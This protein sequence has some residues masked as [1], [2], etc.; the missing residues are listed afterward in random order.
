MKITDLE[1]RISFEY[2]TIIYT[3]SDDE[4]HEIGTMQEDITWHVNSDE[5]EDRLI[6]DLFI[7]SIQANEPISDFGSM[8]VRDIEDILMGHEIEYEG[9]NVSTHEYYLQEEICDLY[10]FADVEFVPDELSE[11][12][13][14]QT[15]REIIEEIYYKTDDYEMQ[16]EEHEHALLEGL[17]T[18]VKSIARFS[19]EGKEYPI[20]LGQIDFSKIENPEIIEE[21]I[22]T[23]H[24]QFCTNEIIAELP[25]DTIY[26]SVE[27]FEPNALAWYMES[28]NLSS[29]PVMVKAIISHYPRL[30]EFTRHGEAG[31][32]EFAV[33][34]VTK[35]G[36]MLENVKNALNNDIDVV[37]AAIQQTVHAI[38]F[39]SDELLDNDEIARIAFEQEEGWIAL[40]Y[41]SERFQD[42]K[43][44]VSRLIEQHGSVIQ[45]ASDSLKDD[46]DIAKIALEQEDGW[47]ALRHLSDRYKGDREIGLWAAEQNVEAFKLLSEELRSDPEIAMKAVKKN[48]S[49][50]EMTFKKVVDAIGE[51]LLDACGIEPGQ[52]Y[53][54]VDEKISLISSLETLDLARKLDLELDIKKSIKDPMALR[55]EQPSL[56]NGASK[57][58]SNKLKV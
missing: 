7:K 9:E 43:D 1:D 6:Q 10:V 48:I 17:A 39:A 8:F 37:K 55:D 51:R 2:G 29:D 28:H 16:T 36:W 21:I 18:K 32:K 30:L 26:Q 52:P 35:D 44:L 22:Q 42:D 27:H 31:I 13:D 24:N 47:K 40:K 15:L 3:D 57:T 4:R 58:K 14:E 34:A 25:R 12:F 56:T 54:T 38:R 53:Y 20:P 19:R 41:L 33:L 5:K 49:N 50:N 23:A 11:E 46:A 45:Y